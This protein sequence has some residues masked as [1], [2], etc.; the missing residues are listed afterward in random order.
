MTTYKII[1]FRQASDN[2]VVVRGLSLEQAQAHCQRDDTHGDGWF[3]GYEEEDTS[4]RWETGEVQLWLANEEPSY[5]AAL[6]CR[7]AAEME[8]RF[9]GMAGPR[10]D[11][12]V[13][14]WDA[15]F[16]HFAEDREGS[17]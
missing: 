12:S 17:Y 15:V 2:E 5:R 13:V 14:D 4:G 16:E 10:V 6:A 8:Q 11:W 3:D 9:T 7:N 1:R